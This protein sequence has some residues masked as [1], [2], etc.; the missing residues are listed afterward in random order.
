MC[1]N[2]SNIKTQYL[3]LKKGKAPAILEILIE[4][5]VWGNLL[6]WPSNPFQG[7]FLF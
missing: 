3:V 7:K 6:S 2:I 5:G 1:K 4:E